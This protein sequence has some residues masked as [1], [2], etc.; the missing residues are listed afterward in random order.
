MGDKLPFEL[1]LVVRTR[2]FSGE[3]PNDVLIFLGLWW[4][5]IFPS[6]IVLTLVAVKKDFLE[7]V[8]SLGKQ[9]GWYVGP[10]TQ[11]LR[12]LL[13]CQKL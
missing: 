5:V 10:H 3:A 8:Q 13:V 6:D 4:C 12:T 9:T 7:T 11:T 2:N 1:E